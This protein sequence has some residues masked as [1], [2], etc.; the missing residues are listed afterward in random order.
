MTTE[1]TK[2]TVKVDPNKD[3]EVACPHCGKTFV[4]KVGHFFK[5]LGI[6]IVETTAEITLGAG[7]PK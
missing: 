3:V 4:Y 6:A 2:Q 1:E 7:Q 5:A